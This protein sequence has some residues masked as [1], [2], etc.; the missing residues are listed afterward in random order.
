MKKAIFLLI[1]VTIAGTYTASAQ[2]G[3]FQRRTPE[4]QLKAVK[5]KLVD[6]KLT[7]E[8]TTKSDSAFIK[9]F[10]TRDKLFQEMRAGGGMPDRDAMREKNQKM[11]ADRDEELKKIFDEAQYKKW[12]EE[13]EPTLR[14]QRRP[15]GGGGNN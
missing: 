5:E 12:K 15:G 1:T 10:R 14:P 13:I 7:P 2:G 4:E 9:Y 6:L 3:G 8:Q 11:M